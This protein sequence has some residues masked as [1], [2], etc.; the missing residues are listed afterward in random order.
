MSNMIAIARNTLFAVCLLLTP[1]AWAQRPATSVSAG[2][3]ETTSSATVNTYNT[4]NV[5]QQVSTFQT[6][7]K[8]RMQGGAYLFDQTYN[9]AF[10]DPSITAAI[11]QAKSVLTSAGAVSFTGPTQLSSNQSTTS[12][13][14][15][16]QTG[17]QSQVLLGSADWIGP[18]TISIGQRGACASY[19]LAPVSTSNASGLIGS[20]GSY[21]LLSGCS[22]GQ[23]YALASGSQDIDTL[24]TSLV[25]IS[26]T[27]TT[28]NT[29]LTSQVYEL[30]GLAAG[31]TPTPPSATP[32][33][34][35]LI[36][37]LIGLALAGLY[38]ARR[39][40]HA[41]VK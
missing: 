17:T 34:P 29:T 19:T 11:T 3:T 21:A 31:A 7:L 32:A 12:A 4:T 13:T 25:T 1:A 9:V 28:T 16:A 40:R 22:G 23:S 2:T 26:Q 36:L 24:V 33:P 15:T 37:C 14:N 27:V 18:V 39:K 10:T 20:N 38:A 5:T 8:A 30:D 35:S 6:E 41:D